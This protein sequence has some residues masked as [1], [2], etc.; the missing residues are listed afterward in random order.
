MSKFDE[1][2]KAYTKS[3][4][5]YFVYQDES[6]KFALKLANEFIDYFGIPKEQIKYIPAN[7]EPVEDTNY[8]IWGSIHLDNDTFW[9]LG[10]LLTLYEKP[11]IYP[12]QPIK[13]VIKFKKDNS[14]FIV[15]IKNSEQEFKINPLIKT[16]YYVFYDHIYDG[17]KIMFNDQLQQFLKES[18]SIKTFGFHT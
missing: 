5:D 12:N 8:T 1:L 16:D 9:H 17:I 18:S 15:K 11:N 6:F 10:I 13:I 14:V 2:C 4:N 3:R 7:K